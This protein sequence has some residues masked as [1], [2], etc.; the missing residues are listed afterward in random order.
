MAVRWQYLQKQLLACET[1][2][3]GWRDKNSF[4]KL[5][6][7]DVAKAKEAWDTWHEVTTAAAD[8]KRRKLELK[9]AISR[10]SDT[11]E[12]IFREVG[13]KK[14]V[15]PDTVED[16]YKQWQDIRVQAEV[17]KEQDR[18][19][20]ERESQIASLGEERQQ[21]VQEQQELLKATGAQTEG[22][23]RSKVLRFRQFHQY[24]EV[25]DQTEAHI[26]LI[27]KTP[28]NLAEL[29][30]ELKIHTLKTWT[31]ERDYYQKKSPMPKRNWLK[32]QKTRQYH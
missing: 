18:Q 5:D 27:A 15:S 17:A 1:A 22:E 6:T 24:K 10:W 26:R 8:W 13:V 30:H 20:K 16:V 14:A 31:D 12:Q 11:A 4:S 3:D 28:K 29:R 23:F 9:G 21:R 32:S 2:W 19:Q 25:Y 7:A